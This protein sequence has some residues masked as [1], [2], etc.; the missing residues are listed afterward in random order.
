MDGDYQSYQPYQSR[1]TPQG[2]PSD[3]RN[4]HPGAH[5]DSAYRQLRN[6]RVYPSD[7][8]QNSQF[9]PSA[10]TAYTAAPGPPPPPHRSAYQNDDRRNGE[11]GYSQS[12]RTTSTVTP[13]VDNM[14]TVAAGGGISGIA[15]GVAHSNERESGVEAMRGV[16]NQGNAPFHAPAERAYNTQ[17]SDTP[18]VPSGPESFRSAAPLSAAAAPAGHATPAAGTPYLNPSDRSIQMGDYPSSQ[19][20]NPARY[21]DLR[22]QGQSSTWGNRGDPGTINPD[23]IADDGDDG[24]IPD[25]K[26]RSVLSIGRNSSRDAIAP[27]AG[28]AAAGGVMGTIG[29]LVGRQNNGQDASGTYGPVNPDTLEDGGDHEEK[30]EWLDRQTHGNKKMMWIVG[31]IIGVVIVAAVVG[32]VVGGVLNNGD[33]GSSGGS[34]Q[35]AEDD[36]DANGDLGKDSSEIQD[37][38]GN[39][40]LHKV[41]PGMDYTPWGTQYPLCHKYPPSQNNVT[42][43]IAVL[44]KLTNNV[45]LYGTDCNQTE[46]VLHAIDRLELTDMKLW[47]GVWLDTNTTTNRRQ[48]DQLYKVLDDTEDKSIFNG[49]IIGNEALYRAGPNIA[50]AQQNL[51]KYMDE[52]RDEFKKKDIDMPIATSDL[53]DNW[54][55][56]LAAKADIVMAN[57]HPF[58]AGVKVDKAA[59]WTLNFWEEHNVILTEGT[60]KKN[61]I[62][63]VGWPSGGGNNCGTEEACPNDTDG[64]V[65]GVDELNKFME[66]WVCDNLEKGTEYFWFEAFDEPWKES[67]N[68]P[69]KGFEWEDKWG[70][71]DPGRNLKPGLKIPD[72]GGKTVS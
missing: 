33:D 52:V 30:S 46:M 35:S 5:P 57:V 62:S 10:T 72:C 27:A 6:Q 37:L 42:R 61:I 3:G 32:G 29:G 21:E 26:R 7:Q 38:M 4:Y 23:D 47:L 48:I 56:T 71:M 28:G 9:V 36:E 22:Y 1:G 19:H 51:I 14:G 8:N 15:L 2:P 59:A 60:D 39:E 64:S 13:G 41:F 69:E 34:G 17:G 70:L 25:P 65:A 43:D 12:M 20:L 24:F 53:G 45:R 18:Y 40:N 11:L 66:D 58:F 16:D 68:E 67:F 55:P 63:E 31:L 44:S 49:A 50:T 54:N